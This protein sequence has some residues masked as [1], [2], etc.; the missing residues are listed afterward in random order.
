MTKLKSKRLLS[1]ILSLAMV[2]TVTT[3]PV[4]AA[5]DG[6]DATGTSVASIGNT[7]YETLADAFA[8]ASTGDTITLEQ[9]VTVDESSK[10]DNGLYQV[11]GDVTL[12]LTIK[13]LQLPISAHLAF[14]PKIHR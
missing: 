13:R 4:F 8:A 11:S 6:T 7:T 5:D 14:L 2:F 10:S 9:D 1:L 12:I 3:A